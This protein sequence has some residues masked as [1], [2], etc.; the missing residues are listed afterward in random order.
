MQGLAGKR[1]LLTAGAAGIG[2]VIAAA[3]LAEGAWVWICDVDAKA[4]A[5]ARS[6]NPELGTS[7]ADVADERAI[8]AMFGTIGE[9][10]GGL[11]ILINNAGISGPTGPIESLDPAEWRRCVAVNLDGAFL[12][13]RRAVPLLKAAGGGAV[14]NISS[15]AGLMGY[16][17]RTPYAAAKW[18]VIGLTRSLAIE[19]GPS[20]IRVNAIC[21]GSVE[22]ARMA[23]AIRA[24]AAVRGVGEE[25]VRQAYIRTTSLRCFVAPEDIAAMALFLCSDLGA[26]ISGQAIAVDGHTE[27]LSG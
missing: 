7:L 11:D 3:F 5:A 13:T 22:G 2:A 19:L 18:G 15:T 6:T 8:D 23:R 4:L 21:P 9:A 24:E 16:P 12:C 1:V 27:G 20:G 17:L 26:N 10:L 25:D 14:V